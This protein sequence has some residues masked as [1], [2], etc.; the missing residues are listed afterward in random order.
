[1]VKKTRSNSALFNPLIQA[2]RA[3][4]VKK[5]VLSG[6]STRLAIASTA[7][8]LSDM[9]F[10]VYVIEDNVLDD[11]DLDPADPNQLVKVYNGTTLSQST[12]HVNLTDFITPITL[13]DAKSR[14]CST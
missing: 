1:M 13:D 8:Y 3:Q 9:D 6:V 10:L 2:L 5:V 4:S 7:I 12:L 11:G 14:L